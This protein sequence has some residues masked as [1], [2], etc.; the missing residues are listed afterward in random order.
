MA[1][2]IIR[3]ICGNLRTD[4]RKSAGKYQAMLK[5][6]MINLLLF[7]GAENRNPK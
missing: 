7:R 3:K 6:L 4:L 2:K 5:R 1:L